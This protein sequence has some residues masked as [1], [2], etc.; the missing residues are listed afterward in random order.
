MVMR[1]QHVVTMLRG[2]LLA[3]VLACTL[4]TQGDPVME[5]F[6][7][8][9][10]ATR[11]LSA[12][13]KQTLHWTMPP[14]HVESSGWFFYQAP[15]SLCIK[16]TNANPE[17][18]VVRGSDLYIKRGSQPRTHALLANRNGKPTQNVQFLLSVFQNGCTNYSG[19]FNL[20][21]SMSTNA[22]TVTLTPKDTL[23]LFPLRQ[24]TNLLDWPSMEICSMR[25]GLVFNSYIS[26]EFRNVV[27][28]HTL[29]V[30]VFDLPPR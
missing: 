24:V 4:E 19:L 10:V 14:R 3:C 28:N 27:R 5:A 22:M 1:N 9:Q 6:I 25:I 17:I 7:A 16:L 18:V 21:T 8:K 11:T 29:A 30:D 2:T 26:Y 23:K 13:L 20:R 15:D 12:D